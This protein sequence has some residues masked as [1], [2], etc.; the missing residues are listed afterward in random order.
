VLSPAALAIMDKVQCPDGI[1]GN[2]V[3][4][5]ATLAAQPHAN[6][7]HPSTG[8]CLP[9]SGFFVTVARSGDRK[10]TADRIALSAIGLMEA[11]LHDKHEAAQRLYRDAH[12]VYVRERDLIKKDLKI[13]TREE[14][15]RRLGKLGPEPR[16]PLAPVIKT[17]DPTLEGLQKLM[18]VGQ[19]SMGLFTD[20]GG[21]FVGGYSFQDDFKMRSGAGLSSFW[22]GTPNDRVRGGDGWMLLRGKRLSIH[23]MIQPGIADALLADPT[24]QSQGLASRFLVSAPESLAGTRMPKRPKPGTDPALK[25]YETAILKLMR[26][27][28]RLKDGRTELDPLPILLSKEAEEA[29]FQFARECELDLRSGGGFEPILAFAAKMGEHALRLAAVLELVENPDAN[30]VRLATFQ[31]AATLTRYY[32]G[33]ALRLFENGAISI[34][35]ERAKNLLRWLHQKGKTVVGFSEIYQYGP[36]SIRVAALAREAIGILE[37]HNWVVKIEG[38]A[39]I[40]GAYHRE[41]WDVVMP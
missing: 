24:L 10:T 17:S 4:A 15:L 35:L 18:A 11:E 9:L 32:A 39:K 29:W 12:E 1:A 5:A 23:I 34:E 13:K 8:Q 38:G 27:P 36:N 2:S 40:G 37:R 31:N 21:T 41:A 6:V 3:L 16:P 14:R 7:V 20:E 25:K 33:E 22:D 30:M 28:Y 19:P 26:K